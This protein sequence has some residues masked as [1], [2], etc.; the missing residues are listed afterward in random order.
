MD[1]N[2]NAG[3]T[4][5]LSGVS[6]IDFVKALHTYLT[7][8][9]YLEVCTATGTSLAVAGCDTIAVDPRFAV[10]AGATGNR[11]R[12]FFFQMTSDDFVATEDA[13]ALLGR[14]VDIAFPDGLR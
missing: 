6:Y 14:P 12:T 5:R 7:P 3:A 9:R 8:R 1:A 4:F 2:D 10:D 11:R 13:P